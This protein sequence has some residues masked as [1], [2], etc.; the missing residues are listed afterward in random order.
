MTNQ[1]ANQKTAKIDPAATPILIGIA[2]VTVE[3]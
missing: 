1:A 2:A 3:F